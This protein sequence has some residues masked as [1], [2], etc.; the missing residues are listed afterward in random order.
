MAST[1][2]TAFIEQYN[3]E[4]HNAYQRDGFKMHRM[5]RSGSV[6]GDVVYWQKVGAL[7]TQGKTRN[8]VHNFQDMTHTVVSATMVDR[9]VPTI[10]DKLDLLKLN[11]DEMRLHAVNHMYALGDW[12]DQQIYDVILAGVS[13]TLGGGD[14]VALTVDHMLEVPEKFNDNKVPNDGRRYCMVSP[15][16]WTKMLGINEFSNADYV[17]T[18]NL[19]Y[20][21]LM[22]KSWAGV[23]WF[24]DTMPTVA[25]TNVASNIAW[26]AQCVGHGINKE[27]ETLIT[28]ENTMSANVAVSCVSSAAAVIDDTG[29]FAWAVDAAA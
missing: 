25:G 19:V 28:Y 11:I 15:K 24:M 29:C 26:H 18:D 4:A 17:G 6:T 21:N 14:A 12:A 22:A 2:S 5:T 8:G 16:T 10:I 9:Y 23:L 1:I 7:T 27:F 13:E 3:A 20:K